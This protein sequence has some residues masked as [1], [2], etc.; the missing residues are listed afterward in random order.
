MLHF[1]KALFLSP[2][3]P[4][5]IWLSVSVINAMCCVCTRRILLCSPC[6][7]R[8]IYQKQRFISILL[9][10][11]YKYSYGRSVA[12][13]ETHRHKRIL[14]IKGRKCSAER[15]D[16]IW[17]GLLFPALAPDTLP[18][19]GQ[20]RGMKAYSAEGVVLGEHPLHLHTLV[21]SWSP[22]TLYVCACQRGRRDPPL[23]SAIT[24]HA[25]STLQV[26]DGMGT[27]RTLPL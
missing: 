19:V 16:V 15:A 2:R 5:D 3:R 24:S 4:R 10:F 9:M 12:R 6:S 26:I 7:H 25:V 23:N 27:T 22:A 14:R 21:P 8:R 18:S 11:S 20:R 1:I 17:V 13:S